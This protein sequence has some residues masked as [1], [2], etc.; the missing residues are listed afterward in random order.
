M[1][2]KKIFIY[3]LV[4]ALLIT[5]ISGSGLENVFASDK[6]TTSESTTEKQDNTSEN[7]VPESDS[8]N[9]TDSA[10]GVE[11]HTEEKTP[12]H[13]TGTVEKTEEENGTGAEPATTSE[14]ITGDDVWEKLKSSTDLVTIDETNKTISVKAGQA[15]TLLSNCP[16]DKY[17][18]YTISQASSFTGATMSIPANAELELNGVNY[19]F[20]FQGL[21]TKENPF[22]GTFN[23]KEIKI[24]SALFCGL[25]SATTFANNNDKES[26]SVITDS[27]NGKANSSVLAE[28]YVFA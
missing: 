15:I 10:S 11:N 5:S 27:D 9:D 14:N 21:G 13:E 23:I 20:Q 16:A 18:D 8:K 19:Q 28:Y 12:D 17:H 3:L 2:G 22:T 25:S 24:P 4:L 1:K 26:L 6:S 7:S